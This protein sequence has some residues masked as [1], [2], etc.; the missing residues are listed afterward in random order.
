[1]ATELAAA[2]VTII[3][4][5]KGASKTIEGA[6]SGVSTTSAGKGMGKS[7]VSGIGGG[8]A[9]LGKVG[10][11]AIGAIGTAVG[12]LAIGGG[13]SRAMKLDQAEMK[14]EA[15]GI[16]VE[17][18]M[19][20][21]NE[22][23]TGTAYGLDAAA[24]VAASLGASGVQA[25]DEM[26]NALK[27]V[28]GMSAMSGVSMEHMGV[29]FGKVASQ[30]KLQGDE[31]TQ[32]AE[33]GVNATAALAKHLGVSQA[34][35]RELV[36][37]GKVDFQTFADAMYATFGDAAQGANETFSGAMSNIGAALSRIGAK[38][39]SPALEGL[40]RVFVAL[41]PAID[42]VAKLLDPLVEKFTSFVNA[43]SDNAVAAIEAFTN[44][45]SNGGS[46]ID[47]FRAAFDA[48]PATVQKAAGAFAGLAGV[49]GAGAIVSKIAQVGGAIA[50][51]APKIAGF[52]TKLAGFAT[53]LPLVGGLFTTLGSKVRLMGSAITLCGGGFKGFAAVMG[54]V[55]TGPVGIVLGLIAA[56]AAGFAYLWNTSEPFK[57]QMTELGSQLMA[58]LQPSLQLIM[59]TLSNMAASVMP[60]ITQA[61]QTVVPIIAQVIQAIVE[62]MAVLIPAI[63]QIIAVVLPVIAQIIAVVV[64]V[65]ST[66]ISAVL[67]VI[68]TIMGVIQSAMPIIQEIITTVVNI[69]SNLIQT[70]MP[71]IQQ[72]ITKVMSIVQQVIQKVWPVVQRIIEV[73]MQVIDAVIQKVWPVI[74]QIITTV[75]DVVLN[76]IQTAWPAIQS[77]IELAMSVIQGVIDTVWPIISGVI[78]AAMSVIQGVI[79]AGMAIING[80]WEGAWN[81]IKDALS[82]AWDSIKTGVSNGIDALMEFLG[83]VPGKVKG[84][85]SD[86]GSW[87]LDAGS[88]IISGLWDGISGSLDWLGDK[89]GGI[90]DFIAEHKGPE[91][92]DLKLLIP[93]GGWIMEGLNTG[94]ERGL[95]AL[96]STLAGVAGE[97]QDFGSE[98]EPYGGI[99]SEMRSWSNVQFKDDRAN[100]VEE[101]VG[102]LQQYLPE[103]AKEKQLV[104]DTGV[105]AG[106]LT[107]AIDK[108]LG[109]RNVRRS[110]G[111]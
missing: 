94:I 98:L 63:A 60:V 87:L 26:T 17:S 35:V 64:Q 108:N 96:R 56:L 49:I 29:I 18:A 84:F 107:P 4:S 111:L 27:A 77:A 71:L 12:G 52:A 36:S 11:G 92:Y 109:I 24:T 45:L 70:A 74:Q 31:L 42:A 51:F 67:P 104:M 85:F 41:I 103:M 105:V 43:A 7:L 75:M 44:A 53:K 23:V 25:G 37:A 14:F 66:V 13:I 48:L 61:I 47:G 89:L 73:A 58:S 57:N 102:L 20:S 59:D 86:A 90:G 2:Y 50:G 21:C 106:A 22:A 79:D 16:N 10:V 6:L 101:V 5:L 95:P 3:P 38:F 82:S 68:T 34:E 93:N 39:A 65:A 69:V 91:S 76:I 99:N 1:M 97:I 9:A 110:K 55:L 100:V 81:I 8:L 15:M 28:A 88:S 62:V 78:D 19:K 72:I 83:E 32:F 54:G 80:D 33:N 46:I 30:G 40:R